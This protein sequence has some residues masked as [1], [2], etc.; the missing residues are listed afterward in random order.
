LI[1]LDLYSII[2]TITY[3]VR[4]I[5]KE[6]KLIIESNEKAKQK[7]G[8]YVKPGDMPGQYVVAGSVAFAETV[9]NRSSKEQE[10]QGFVAEVDPA[11]NSLETTWEAFDKAIDDTKNFKAGSTATLVLASHDKI[12]VGWMGDSPV[13]LARVKDGAISY[14]LLAREHDAVNQRSHIQALGGE[15]EVIMWQGKVISSSIK[16]K[17]NDATIRC[18]RVLGDEGYDCVRRPEV[19]EFKIA[20]QS[21]EKIYVIAA[22]DGPWFSPEVKGLD[23]YSEFTNALVRGDASINL[24]EVLAREAVVKGSRDNITVVVSPLPKEGEAALAIGIFDGHSKDEPEGVKPSTAAKMAMQSVLES[25]SKELSQYGKITDSAEVS[26]IRKRVSKL[27]KEI[28]DMTSKHQ[29][30]LDNPQ[31][32]DKIKEAALLAETLAK[33]IEE[34]K[35]MKKRNDA[36]PSIEQDEHLID[37]NKAPTIENIVSHMRKLLTLSEDERM[38]PTHMGILQHWGYFTQDKSLEDY[39]LEVAIREL[40]KEKALYTQESNS[41]AS[42]GGMASSSGYN[43]SN[44]D[45]HHNE[46][47]AVGREREGSIELMQSLFGMDERDRGGC[48]AA[49]KLQEKGFFADGDFGNEVVASTLASLLEDDRSDFGRNPDAHSLVEQDEPDYFV[50]DNHGEFQDRN[51][52]HNSGRRAGADHTTFGWLASVARRPFV[53]AGLLKDESR[54]DDGDRNR[55]IIIAAVEFI[56]SVL[57]SVKSAIDSV[58]G[59]MRG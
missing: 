38:N 31:S 56:S 8:A 40:E 19:A 35:G 16:N 46:E 21:G 11:L 6:Y 33:Q 43:I 57:S 23:P 5:M 39:K 14:E 42:H 30:F 24:A 29:G 34:L 54:R 9:G 1:K 41:Y 53:W 7:P 58:V 28:H 13:Y 2:L 55:S 52:N 4:N 59:R 20:R 12:T 36:G 18:G 15:V 45:T 22:C 3:V 49:R 51:H 47:G 10:D 48:E 25:R 32:Y 44:P 37:G 17:N 26:E 27:D 50:V